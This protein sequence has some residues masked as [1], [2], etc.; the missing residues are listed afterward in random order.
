MK[1]Y[2]QWL[3][4]GLALISL[5]VFAFNSSFDTQKQI[6]RNIAE[7]SCELSLNTCMFNPLQP[8]SGSMCNI[9]YKTCMCNA[10]R[11]MG[12]KAVNEC[13]RNYHY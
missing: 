7:D 2:R 11:I 9:R 1:D 4:L 13:L 5:N 8:K 10:A 12:V 3:L 6:L